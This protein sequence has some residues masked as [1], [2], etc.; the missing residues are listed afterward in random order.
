M[1]SRQLKQLYIENL[2]AKS[3]LEQHRPYLGMSGISQCP[4]L[5]YNQFTNGRG[6]QPIQDHWHCREG[7]KEQAE[8]LEM[9]GAI[10][11]K[12]V[13]VI[14]EWD[15]RYKGHTDWETPD[16]DLVEIKSVYW[17]KFMD[18]VERRRAERQHYEQVQAYLRHGVWKLAH[19]CYKARDVPQEQWR[20]DTI[21]TCGGIPVWIVSVGL[22][23]EV[24]DRLDAKARMILGA[25]DR[26]V[27]PDCVCGRCR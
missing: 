5:L 6:Y 23:R 27:A 11:P 16:G 3:G 13:E 20:G 22:N 12:G 19:I 21:A 26:G 15:A 9:L 17:D 7:Y 2:K 10:N 18:I 4:R 8:A 25:I 14:A 1:D 24:A